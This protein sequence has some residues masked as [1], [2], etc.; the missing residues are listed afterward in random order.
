MAL[1]ELT[2]Q[3]RILAHGQLSSQ[4]SPLPRASLPPA[5]TMPAPH[6]LGEHAHWSREKQAVL[7]G[8]ASPG[9]RGQDGLPAGVGLG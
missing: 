3:V 6:C 4:A 8:G 2:P 5:H 9:G 1:P 7:R